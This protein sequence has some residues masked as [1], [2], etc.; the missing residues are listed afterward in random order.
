[1]PV[2]SNIPW[3]KRL[4]I[5]G[6]V[7][8]PIAYG[9][10]INFG[11]FDSPPAWDSAITV[12]PA[13][14]TI[15]DRGFDVWEVAQLPSSPEGGP[16]THATSV[17]TIALAGLIFLL[18]ASTAFYTAHVASLAFVGLLVGGTYLFARERASVPIS[19]L[20]AVLVGILPLVVQQA[21]DVYLDLPLAVVTTFACW[22]ASRRR[23]WWTAALV[24]MGV[25]IKTSG[26][27]LLPLLLFAKPVDRPF[28]R[29]LLYASP[30]GLVASLP[31]LLSLATTHRFSYG[32]NPWNDLSLI[33]SSASL[34]ALT[35]DVF[36]VLSVYL[37]VINARSRSRSLD[38]PTQASAIVV[39]GFFAAHLATILLSGTIAILP[40]YYIAILPAVLVALVP[41]ANRR[42]ATPSLSYRV[43]VG[44][45]LALV[46]FSALNVRGDFYWVPNH[47]FYVVAERSTRAQDL[48]EMQV[49]GTRELAAI[50]LPLL[51]GR[52][53]FFRLQY[54]EMGYVEATP[55]HIIPVF[56]APVDELP[57]EFAM[58]VEQRFPNPLIA[59]EEAAEDQGYELSYRDLAVG[60]FRSKLV[61]A[62]K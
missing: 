1:M 35:T 20:I 38:R 13:A 34:L 46:I 42:A 49:I 44:F 51:V 48:L 33:R 57:D 12:S 43:G 47:D 21:A 32:T 52:Q 50:D 56:I 54:P 15:V 6:A 39:T 53:V 16:S 4:T 55:E 40:R 58:L 41:A 27:F 8:L 17:Y 62:S 45:I 37:L 3:L 25:A 22:T 59:I 23:F 19:A 31:F 36:L 60:E 9:L 61:I 11:Q 14:L 10:G 24:V 26:L 5:V 7:A 29:H 2:A 18:G 28:A 30:A